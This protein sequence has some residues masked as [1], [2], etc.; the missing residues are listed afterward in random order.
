MNLRNVKIVILLFSLMIWG[1]TARATSLPTRDSQATSEIS[2]EVAWDERG[3]FRE[4]LIAAEQTVLE[5]LP[6]ASV[7]HIDLRIADDYLQL[8]GH[9]AVRYTNREDVAL[10]IVYFQIL[11]NV[12]GGSVTV[13]MVAVDGQ[14]VEPVYEF[15]DVD[16]HPSAFQVPLPKALEPGAQVVIQ[17]DFAIEVPQEMG[18]NYG[19]FGYFDDV[20]VLDVFYP[21]IPVY[22]DEG[23]NVAAPS[24]HGDLTYFDAS[25]YVV[26][27][28]APADAV[29]AASGVAIAQEYTDNQQTLTF[30]AGPARDFYLAASEA[31]LVISEVVG[32]TTVNSYA[33]TKYKAHADLAL[34]FA[35]QALESFNARFGPYPYT[36][37]DVASTPMRASGIEYPGVIGLSLKLYDPKAQ[38]WGLPSRIVLESV[39]AHEV[40]HQWF[41]NVVGNDQVDEPWLDEAL[42]QYITGLYYVDVQGP[43][44]ARSYRQSWSSSWDRVERAE[45]PIGLPSRMYSEE[46]Y[47]PIVYGRGP[48]FI[49]ALAEAMGQATFDKFLRAYY[50]DHQWDIATSEAF[51][52]LAQEHCSTYTKADCD[53]TTLFETWVYGE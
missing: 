16:G 14:A 28:T 37:F 29:I 1:C 38:V 51:K 44:G 35:V 7:Y 41:Y 36:E 45:I 40:A 26:Q 32:E 42:V 22:D 30:A 31:Y 8:E 48:L 6:G 50:Q 17:M 25:F 39:V 49:M 23:W 10:D 52:T 24:P 47:S 18:G 33:L 27:V 2:W 13:S 20:L 53:V 34:R 15:P 3:I 11:P 4:G 21:V 43:S 46:A 9:E 19:L 12:S 5:T